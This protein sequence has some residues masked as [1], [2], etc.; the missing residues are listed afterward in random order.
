[1]HVWIDN[2][3]EKPICS[4]ELKCAKGKVNKN[5]KTERKREKKIPNGTEQKPNSTLLWFHAVAVALSTG[6][7]PYHMLAQIIIN[8]LIIS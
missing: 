7:T 8:Y 6:Q 1:M 3:I 4:H 2:Q 5:N